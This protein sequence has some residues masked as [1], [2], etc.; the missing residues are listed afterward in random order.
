MTPDEMVAQIE[1]RGVTDRLVLRAMRTVPR[2]RFVPERL[3]RNAHDDGPLPIGHGQTIS[4]P[5]I[6]AYMTELLRVGPGSRV[7][8]IG[9]GSGYQTAVLAELAGDVFSVEVVPALARSAED[10]L[11]AL[12]YSNVHV[13]CGDGGLGW[14]EHA[15]FDRIM[16]TAA[17][18]QVPPAVIAQLAV[19]GRLVAPVGPPGHTQWITLLERTISGVTEQRTIAVRFVPF[20]RATA[21]PAG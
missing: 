7:L 20:N 18:P 12:G 15:P 1:S 19:D 3:S 4:Q 6:V 13:L 11:R 5:Y 21:E 2:E 16:L 8:E 10:I 9:T 14:P 17:P